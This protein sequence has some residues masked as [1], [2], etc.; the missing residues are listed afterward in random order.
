MKAEYIEF[1]GEWHKDCSTCKTPY[2]AE[3]LEG[4]FT[5][6]QKD[7]CNEGD[8]LD[9]VCKRCR[10]EYRQKNK[11]TELK[12]WKRYYAPGTENYKR[13]RVRVATRDKYGPASIHRCPDCGKQAQEWHHTTYK[14]DTV[15]PLC[16]PCHKDQKY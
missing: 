5:F 2:G 12:R 14:V 16:R 10:K 6:F 7:R 8:G 11:S 13:F 3:T 15:V 1:N 9:V 4:L